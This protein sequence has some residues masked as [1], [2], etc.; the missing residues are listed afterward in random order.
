MRRAALLFLAVLLPLMPWRAVAQTRI[1][2]VIGVGEYTSPD[3]PTLPHAVKDA[4]AVSAKLGEL[5]FASVL[6]ENPSRREL[7]AG[8][9][10]FF[11]RRQQSGADVMLVFFA[12]HGVRFGN[13][14]YLLARDSVLAPG[15]DLDERQEVPV[16]R[17]LAVV[18]EA[19]LAIIMIDACRSTPSFAARLAWR[20][21]N[22][23]AAGIPLPG[24]IGT[25]A[26]ISYSAEPG[27]SASDGRDTDANSPFASALLDYLD[28]PQLE[29]GPMLQ[30][31]RRFVESATLGAQSPVFEDRRRPGLAFYFRPASIPETAAPSVPLAMRGASAKEAL[32]LLAGKT[33]TTRGDALARIVGADGL[34]PPVSVDEAVDLLGDIPT[35]GGRRRQALKLLLPALEIPISPDGAERL[36]AGLEGASRLAALTAVMGCLA[37]PLPDSLARQLVEGIERDDM[38]RLLRQLTASEGSSQTCGEVHR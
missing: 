38:P 20:S 5:G 14:G 23:V 7:R 37:R 22:T 8:L 32:A 9:S 36:L 27:T 16:A 33:G 29:L 3:I 1:A 6:L 34:L 21:H 35:D 28:R 11:K 12:G 19:K 31:V 2:L 26:V 13:E 30:G 15:A 17:L 24:E 4:R 18:R 25:D 10:Q